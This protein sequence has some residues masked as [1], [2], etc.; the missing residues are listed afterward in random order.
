[1]WVSF[2]SF[3]QELVFIAVFLCFYFISSSNSV[4]KRNKT[5]VQKE[6]KL[7]RN[8]TEPF[9]AAKKPTLL[10]CQKFAT[11]PE[12]GFKQGNGQWITTPNLIETS[13]KILS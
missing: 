6:Q 9:K 4:D 1:M 2:E 7:H 10:I 11:G 8:F 12:S 5:R 13:F 3:A